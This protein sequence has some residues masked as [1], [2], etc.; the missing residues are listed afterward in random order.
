MQHIPNW[1]TVRELAGNVWVIDDN[2]QDTMYLVQGKTKALL[3]DTGLGIGGLLELVASLTPLP[4]IVVNTHGHPD[5]VGGNYQFEDVHIARED[6]PRVHGCFAKEE[7]TWLL[8]NVLQDAPL[9]EPFREFWL[10][11][12]PKNIIAIQPGHTFD[13][14]GRIIKA[15]ALPGHT[16]GCIGLLDE[17]EKM[18]F[19]GDSILAGIIWMHLPESLPLNLFLESLT[20]LNLLADK[21]DIILPG[22]DISP[23]PKVTVTE[24]IEGI[25]AILEGRLRGELHHTIV[26]DGLMSKFN[27]CGIIYRADNLT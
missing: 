25:S 26:G 6:V 2:G 20:R 10:K 11:Q 12:K 4:V 21:F 18:L 24:L 9:S 27:H 16:P 15:V 22:H 19:S 5:H 1:F 13:L 7:R 3:I 17:N 14:G 23:V 8:E